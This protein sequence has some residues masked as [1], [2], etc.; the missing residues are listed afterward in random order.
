MSVDPLDSVIVTV[1]VSL[2]V[3]FATTLAIETPS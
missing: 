1:G 2:S 3:T